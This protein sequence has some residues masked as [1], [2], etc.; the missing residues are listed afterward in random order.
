MGGK[1][2][3]MRAAV[4]KRSD[5]ARERMVPSG[6]FTFFS[7]IAVFSKPPPIRQPQAKSRRLRSKHQVV[8]QE[9]A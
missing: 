5:T 6:F 3:E 4:R 7:W 9:A 8:R 2:C 1:P